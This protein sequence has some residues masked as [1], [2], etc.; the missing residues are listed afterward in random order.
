MRT[1]E[2]IRHLILV[3][4]E[5]LLHEDTDVRETPIKFLKLSDDERRGIIRALRW[6]VDADEDIL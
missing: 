2:Q 1:D 5:L 6:V 4:K 3:Q